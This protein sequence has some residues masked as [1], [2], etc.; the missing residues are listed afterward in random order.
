[1]HNATAYMNGSDIL[2]DEI[3]LATTV[4]RDD[5]L[6]I[7]GWRDHLAEWAEHE[8]SWDENSTNEDG[9]VKETAGMYDGKKHFLLDQSVYYLNRDINL[10]PNPTEEDHSATGAEM[11]GK[12]LTVEGTAKWR[13]L[14]LQ[15]KNMLSLI[16]ENQ[17]VRLQSFTLENVQDDLMENKGD[18]IFDTM[19]MYEAL[20]VNNAGNAQVE[21]HLANQLTVTGRMDID[22]TITTKGDYKGGEITATLGDGEKLTWRETQQHGSLIFDHSTQVTTAAANEQQPDVAA[23]VESMVLNESVVHIFG[24]VEHQDITHRGEDE[25]KLTSDEKTYDNNMEGTK[26]TLPTWSIE[27]FEVDADGVRN[28]FKTNTY[29]DT[30]SDGTTATSQFKAFRDNSLTMEGG[31]FNLGTMWKHRLQLRS[32]D[33][34]GGAVFVESSTINLKDEVMGGIDACDDE[35]D[36]SHYDGNGNAGIKHDNGTAE[37]LIWLGNFKLEGTS[38]KEIV[39]VKFVDNGVGDAVKDGMGIANGAAKSGMRIMS[40]GDL[41]YDWEVTYNDEEAVNSN[42]KYAKDKVGV[43]GMYT[44]RRRG[45]TPE[46]KANPVSQLTG[47]YMTMMQVYN[48]GFQHADMFADSV[49]DAQRE[50]LYEQSYTVVNPTKGKNAVP[51]KTPDRPCVDKNSLRSGLWFNTFT[52]TEKMPLHNGPDVRMETYGGFVGGDSSLHQ[53]SNGWASVW[54]LYGGYVGSTQRYDGVRIRQNGAAIGATGTFYKKQFFTA[55]TASVGMADAR[56]TG[57]GGNETFHPLMGGIASRSG[58]NFTLDNGRYILQPNLML[59]MS[60]FD[61]PS[62]KSATGADITSSLTPVFQ[63]N[64]SVKLIRK[65]DCVWKPYASVGAVFNF[66]GNTHSKIDGAELPSMSI[67]PYVEYSVGVQRSLGE[68]YTIFGQA[69][70]RNGGRNGAELNVGLRYAW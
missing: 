59:S 35:G 52:S 18:L 3:E 48:Y 21:N 64:P 26:Q 54:S 63:V 37:G 11:W 33:V 34:K 56:A 38:N 50:S 1:M 7:V 68:S 6:H 40:D 60:F 24:T 4:T 13:T 22:F 42:D 28:S 30:T 9:S 65:T 36:H 31:A 2:A 45:F 10:V 55:L 67:N 62:Y 44:F 12:Y 25:L 61:T 70:G 41:V 29:L 16:I 49:A 51:G 58:Y 20:T 19:K 53:H 14:D 66:M 69:T 27:G 47:S 46:A 32:F 5:T 8:G 57:R 23:A 43:R 17:Q 15:H 39:H